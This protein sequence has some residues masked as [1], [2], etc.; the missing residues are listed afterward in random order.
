[1]HVSHTHN[2]QGGW[3]RLLSQGVLLACAQRIESET[4]HG[5]RFLD[6]SEALETDALAVHG[7]G[8]QDD[9][10]SPAQ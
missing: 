6:R 5:A 2:M 9:T 10:I 4:R 3:K 7:T 1:M 8:E